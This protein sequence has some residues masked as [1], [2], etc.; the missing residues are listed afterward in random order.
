MATEAEPGALGPLRLI[1]T[2]RSFRL[3]WC[4]RSVSYLGDSLSLV[5]LMLYVADTA[6]QAL[7]VALLL[8]AGD[9]APA[10]LAPLTGAI[11]DRFDLRQVMVGCELVQGGLLAVIALWL[12][13]MPP[14]LA[15][16]ALR[17]MVGQVPRMRRP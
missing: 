17:A 15:L 8:L 16:V 13:S 2:N 7:A 10:L 1:G 5:A 12:P 9:F 6:G 3:L 14:L 11:S 4:A